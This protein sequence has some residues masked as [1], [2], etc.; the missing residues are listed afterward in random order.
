M[1]NYAVIFIEVIAAVVVGVLAG[2]GA[3]YVFNKIPASWLCD[4]DQEPSA[5]LKD[6]YIQRVKGFP[7]K[8]VFSG[9]F[10]AGLINT[11]MYDWRFAAATLVFCW[12]LLLIAIADHKYGIIPDQFVILAAVSAMGFI[13]FHD[14]FWQSAAGAGLGA[15]IMLLVSLVGR[16]LFRKESLGFG[17]VKLFGAIGLALGVKGVL[18]V[19]VMASISSSLIFSVLL[20]KKK[21]KVT[22][23]KPL[24]PYVC[25][26]GI[27]YVAIIWPL[28]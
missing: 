17:D 14:Q 16:L 6:P 3:V 9:F 12:A 19:M 24:G 1:S 25:G 4:Y 5:E 20:I 18:T 22:D 26:C 23:F 28:L 15:G 8:L 11:V 7:W 27:F 21:I 10:T 13:A 2:H